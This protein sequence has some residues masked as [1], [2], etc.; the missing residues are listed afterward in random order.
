MTK[1]IA[2]TLEMAA[3]QRKL[4]EALKEYK[5][6]QRKVIEPRI[7]SLQQVGRSVFR[8]CMSNQDYDKAMEILGD[9]YWVTCSVT[10]ESCTRTGFTFSAHNWRNSSFD[11]VQISNRYTSMSDRDFAKIIRTRCRQWKQ[12]QRDK[13][14]RDL[15][16]QINAQKRALNEAQKHLEDLESQR[17][18][19]R[20]DTAEVVESLN[21]PAV[22]VALEPL[23]HRE[24]LTTFGPAVAMSA[25]S[26][27]SQDIRATRT[28]PQSE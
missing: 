24:G 14:E 17:I 22:S 8:K 10:F 23:K 25:Q 21:E 9:L 15:N 3:E 7:V 12:N 28:S 27:M 16:N 20:R 6:E 5:N 18:R 2:K 13:A 19:R 1:M 11:E 26:R 4:E